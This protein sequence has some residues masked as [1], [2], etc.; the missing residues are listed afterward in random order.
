MKACI[1]NK[2]VPEEPFYLQI[3]IAPTN[4]I[5]TLISAL[6]ISTSACTCRHLLIHFGRFW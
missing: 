2:M 5:N 4:G 1:E 6:P 3:E